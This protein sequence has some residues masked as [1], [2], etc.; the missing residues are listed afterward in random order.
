MRALSRAGF[1]ATQG[2]S[3]RVIGAPPSRPDAQPH[4]AIDTVARMVFVPMYPGLPDRSIRRM[5][6]VLLRSVASPADEGGAS[7]R[8]SRDEQSP[9][10]IAPKGHLRIAQQVTL[11]SGFGR[12]DFRCKS[13]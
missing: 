2:Q 7:R 9:A 3:M 6:E 4:V 13:L 8:P 12:V 10:I 5:A 11:I 1:D